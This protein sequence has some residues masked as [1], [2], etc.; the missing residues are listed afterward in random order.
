MNGIISIHD[1]YAKGGTI[2]TDVVLDLNHALPGDKVLYHVTDGIAVIDS[3]TKRARHLVSGILE[4]KSNIIYGVSSKGGRYYLFRPTDGKYPP[5]IVLS[6]VKPTDYHS[7]I[8]VVI[9][10]LE[11]T[12]KYPRG[13]CEF[14]IGEIG[15]HS[16]EITNRLYRHGLGGHHR[17]SVK[18]NLIKQDL[19][20]SKDPGSRR[21]FL[22]HHI[23]SIDPPGCRDIDDA[24]HVEVHEDHYLL[25]IHIA[26]VDHYVPLDS[27]LDKLAFERMTSIYT[28]E[29][30]FHMLPLE[31]ATD[32]CSLL[33]GKER[34][35]MSLLLK[36]DFNGQ[37]Q[38]YEFVPTVIKVHTNMSYETADSLLT[39]TLAP[40]YN[41]ITLYQSGYTPTTSGAHF[42]VEKAMI[43]ANT[44]CAQALLSRYGS[45]ILRTHYNSGHSFE[46]TYEPELIKYMNICL[47]QAAQYH[48]AHTTDMVHHEGLKLTHYTHFTSPIRRYIDIVNH[49]LLK[50]IIN[51]DVAKNYFQ[52]IC[53]HAN[54]INKQVRRFNRDIDY[55][56]VVHI[57]DQETTYITT[58]AYIIEISSNYS[59]KIYIP[60]Y[61]LTQRIKLCDQEL[62]HL[63]S[64]D[65][66][67]DTVT[68]QDNDHHIEYKLYSKIIIQ[69]LAIP[70]Q[71][72]YG[73]KLRITTG[74]FSN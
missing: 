38:S 31:L 2:N 14:I 56:N 70:K 43:L 61:Q 46:G 72:A 23:I 21:P 10:F 36:I 4:I 9:T 6:K 40:L 30:T 64:F 15:I 22:N 67:H 39:T 26:D 68:I 60:K 50:G 65:H 1:I 53:D 74:L 48:H 71:D 69:M 55:L 37:L 63:Y 54:T 66:Q 24:L 7:H 16:N 27:H 12:T 25:G 29:K 57:L 19:K 34:Y 32:R 47:N 58:E 73:K 3:I 28:D 41:L 42:L 17:S 49:R 44:L 62:R 51:I 8:Y 5:F 13:N 35:A 52:Q 18:T 59:L 33:E 45:A 20:L 11:W